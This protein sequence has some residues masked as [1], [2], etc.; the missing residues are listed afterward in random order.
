MIRRALQ[1]KNV[2]YLKIQYILMLNSS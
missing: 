2:S 1:L